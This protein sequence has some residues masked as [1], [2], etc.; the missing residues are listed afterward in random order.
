MNAPLEKQMQNPTAASTEMADACPVD[1]LQG[2]W[3]VVQT[4]S[5]CEKALAG[6]LGRQNIGH[7]LPLVQKQRRHGGRLVH[8][9]FPLFAGYLFLCGGDEERYAALMT[10][11]A[12]HIIPVVNQSQIRNE[13]R[14]IHRILVSRVA[15]DLYPKL[16][17]GT[18][19]RV[20]A[21]SLA[22]LEGVVLRR[23]DVTRI[24][25]GVNALG[26]SAEMEID[27][28]LLEPIE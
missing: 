23:R 6:D 10:H 7:F 3:W 2:Q 9:D 14:Q 12:A 27:P 4:K 13:L 25:I 26:Q 18:R 21:G 28:A 19:C 16:C 22:G 8:V 1:L 15:V 20:I 11:R 17:K 24:Y 5:R